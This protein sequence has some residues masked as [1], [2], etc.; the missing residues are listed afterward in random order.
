LPIVSTRGGGIPE[1]VEHGRS[2]LIVERSDPQAIAD[3]ILQLLSNP[4]QRDA[5]S[6]TAFERASTRFSWDRIAEDLLEE[7]ERLFV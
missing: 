1:I 7:Y 5:M 3:A 4:D 2:G 6:Q